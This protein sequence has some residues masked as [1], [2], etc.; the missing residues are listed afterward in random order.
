MGWLMTCCKAKAYT[1]LT[2]ALDVFDTV[3][4]GSPKQAV[5]HSLLRAGEIVRAILDTTDG[6]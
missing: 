5:K 4:I 3:C 6:G 2:A 1:A